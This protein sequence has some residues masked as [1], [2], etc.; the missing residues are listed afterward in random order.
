M[1]CS[2]DLC[3][4]TTGIACEIA[5]FVI[6]LLDIGPVSEPLTSLLH[7]VKRFVMPFNRQV[8]LSLIRYENFA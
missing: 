6:E 8:L 3:Q 7:A 5:C 2:A 4:P 1:R